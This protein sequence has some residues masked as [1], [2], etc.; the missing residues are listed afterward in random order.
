MRSAGA[1]IGILAALAL[2]GGK[3]Y[4]RPFVEAI[5]LLEEVLGVRCGGLVSIELG[6]INS[7]ANVH[8]G[9]MQRV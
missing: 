7:G 8:Q 4:E 3:I 6:G 9:R 1:R 5:R 2:G